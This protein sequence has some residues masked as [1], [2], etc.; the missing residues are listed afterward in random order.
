M[1]R[2]LLG[3]PDFNDSRYASNEAK[4]GIVS[5]SARPVG[6]IETLAPGAG[7]DVL[8]GQDDR[9]PLDVPQLDLVARLADDEALVGPAV[10]GGDLLRLEALGDLGARL[11]DRLGQLGAAVAGR[12]AQQRRALGGLAGGDGVAGDAPLP[13]EE[14]LAQLR[15]A[16]LR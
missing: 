16:L 10:D 12:D 7:V 15:V 5:G 9:A 1:T 13:L 11:E 8:L 4:S 3:Q 2:A 6:M 14:P